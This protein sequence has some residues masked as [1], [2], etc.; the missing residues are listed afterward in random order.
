MASSEI[1]PPPIAMLIMENIGPSTIVF[2]TTTTT[3]KKAIQASFLMKP[4]RGFF[5]FIA[6]IVTMIAATS[7]TPKM[8][9]C[10]I[11]VCRTAMTSAMLIDNILSSP[12]Y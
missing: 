3:N 4:L 1:L 10:G 12:S 9:S 6:Q 11:I 8:I 7:A 2:A 5:A